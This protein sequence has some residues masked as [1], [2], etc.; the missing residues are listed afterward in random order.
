MRINFRQGIISY[1]ISGGQAFLVKTGSM[2]SLRAGTS[3]VDVAFAHKDTDYL[4][5][6]SQD[7]DDVWGPIPPST[8]TWLYWDINRLTGARTFGIT[9][10][11]PVHSPV[12]VPGQEGLH[13]F[14]TTNAVMYVYSAG[15]YREVVRV[16]AGK[17][18]NSTFSAL[19]VGFPD[20]PYA[21]SQV[22]IYVGSAPG[23]ILVDSTSKPVRRDNGT[24]FTMESPFFSSGSPIN[25]VRL[26]ATIVSGQ[27]I[28]PMARFQVVKFYEFGKISPANYG[29]AGNATI[30]MLM[31]D[32]LRDDV[33]TVCIQGLI[34]N[35]LWNWQ[36]VGAPLWIADGGDLTEVDPHVANAFV[37]PVSTVPVAR[38]V[39]PTSVI[40]DQG[41]G[42]KGDQGE[43]GLAG[44]VN[45]ATTTLYGVSRLSTN[46]VSASNPIVVGDNDVRLSNKVLKAGDTMTGPLVLSANPV[47]PLGAATKL[48][49]DTSLATVDLS[50]RVAKAGDTMLGPLLLAGLPTTANEATTK[51]YVDTAILYGSG[52]TWK[53]PVR[54]GST[55][56]VPSL[57]GALV[58]DG[59]QSNVGDRVL[60][61]HQSSTFTNGVYTVQT[62]AW[63]RALDSDTPDKLVT[64]SVYYVSEGSTQRFQAFVLSTTGTINVGVSPIAF[65]SFNNN[66]TITLS[67]DAAGS[68]TTSIIATLN[69]SGVTAGTYNQ[70]TV[71]AKGQVTAGAN[72]STLAGHGIVDA[73]HLNGD[74]MTGFLT[75]VADPI[76]PLQAATKQYVDAATGG[77]GFTV[78]G[79]LAIVG[80]VLSVVSANPT[81]IAIGANSIN[82]GTTGVAAGT[83]NQVTVD[84]YGRVTSASTIGNSPITLS[85]DAAGTGT[86]AITVVLSNTGVVAGTYRSITVDSKGRAT[87]G[88]NPTNLS[89]YGITDA[90]NKNGDTMTGA[91]ILGT[92]DTVSASNNAIQRLKDPINPQDAATKNYVDTAVGAVISAGNGL[93]FTGSVLNI[94]PVSTSRIAVAPGTIDLATS[95]VSAGTYTSVQ[96]DVYG[97]VTSGSNPTAILAVSLTGD[98]T[99]SG[100]TGSPIT[101]T[102]ATVTTAGTG[103]NKFD[104]DSKGRVTNATT[105][106]TFAGLG[107]SDS[108]DSLNDVTIAAPTL[109]QVLSYNGSQWVNVSPTAAT[110][111]LVGITA[112]DSTPGYLNGK[113][114]S[115]PNFT[116]TTLYPTGNETLYLELAPPVSLTGGATYGFQTVN[117]GGT[118]VGTTSTGLTAGTT[119]TANVI[120]DGVTYGVSI[121]GS[122]APTIR[123]LIGVINAAITTHGIA[124]LTSGNIR[125][126]S[127]RAGTAS[128]VSLVN[129]GGNP[130]FSS[131][132]GYVS[133]PA[134]TAGTTGG[135]YNTFD[136]DVYGRVISASNLSGT[137]QPITLSGDATGT[138]ATAITVTLADTVGVAGAG[139]FTQVTVDRKGRVTLGANP[140][141]IAGYGITDAQP[142]HAF[143]TNA[144]TVAA[145]GFLVKQINGS[146]PAPGG[147]GAAAVIRSIAGTTGRTT[148]TNGDGTAGNPTIDLA[149]S[150]VVAGTYTKVTFDAY[151]RAVTGSTIT[152]ADVGGLGTIASQNAATVAITG[153]SIS[154]TQVAPRI[155][156]TAY[157]ATVT[158]N[159]AVADIIR[160]TLTGDIVINNTGAV[161]GQKC[162][163]ELLQD[164]TGGRNVTFVTAPTP[165]ARF[166]TDITGFTPTVTANKLDRVG[167]IYRSSTSTYDVV[168]IVRGY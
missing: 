152:T 22:G 139:T 108:I 38:V 2:V 94:V 33:G 65:T 167:M 113:L 40:F 87:A 93:A 157:A 137:N 85:G 102:L 150:G 160:I 48:Y 27:A 146:T 46:P 58:I 42:G 10:V 36:T 123:E 97:R 63:T 116:I 39:T 11:E 30:A 96:V 77:V 104:V 3:P 23:H 37:Y 84:V 91:L 111:K 47:V 7:L 142:L 133:I 50:S 31:E 105:Q 95:G 21:G 24:F 89:G 130:L 118:A 78:G 17:V 128:T 92:S 125:V 9:T 74:I 100:N 25:P 76:L 55:T 41:L 156:T 109:N 51:Q 134:A 158:L 86:S 32:L 12:Q 147:G 129:T 49:V 165:A 163:V 136:V 54:L 155:V 13:W 4:L 29:D 124:S 112:S 81:N 83:Y 166:G 122:T 67:G 148:V 15:Q 127:A 28:E 143:L 80:T 135:T 115:S 107:L 26:E 132:T 101:T 69:P 53:L 151:G 79:G 73:V 159:W 138:G 144:S 149:T 82:L 120:I 8:D 154:G 131:L 66:Q 6:E 168:A 119:Y 117:I 16:F 57:A 5:T 1:P 20:K 161:D 141:T 60:L 72:P 114:L 140:T 110:D 88:S 126:T 75:L 153:G 18:N 62:G 59:V 52:L 19:G 61:R 99:G 56:N 145:T 70:V 45:L 14:D 43:P 35:P 98:V 162:I 121:L 164:A 34:T 44:G 71:N 68:G 90:V 64:G 106:T 103:K